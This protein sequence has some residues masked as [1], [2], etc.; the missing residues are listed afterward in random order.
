MHVFMNVLVFS[1]SFLC[2][3][4]FYVCVCSV[5]SCRARLDTTIIMEETRA[6]TGACALPTFVVLCVPAGY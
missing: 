5:C 3:V 6:T 4:V 1:V 2:T